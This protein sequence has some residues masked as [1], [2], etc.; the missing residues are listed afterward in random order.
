MLLYITSMTICLGG[1]LKWLKNPTI[2]DKSIVIDKPEREGRHVEHLYIS[3][4]IDRQCLRLSLHYHSRVSVES[5]GPCVMKKLLQ[6]CMTHQYVIPYIHEYWV[7]STQRARKF[8]KIQAKKLMKSNKSKFFSWNCIFSS[9]ELF[10]SSKM[11]FWPFLKLQKMEFGQ[12]NFF[13]KLICATEKI[14]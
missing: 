8:L 7:H 4:Y 3:T 1:F 10:P 14:L 9:F 6:K 11:D 5:A 13:V 2:W 12:K